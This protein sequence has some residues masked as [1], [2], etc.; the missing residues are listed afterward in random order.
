[1]GVGIPENCWN[2]MLKS[3]HFHARQQAVDRHFSSVNRLQ[4]Y[5]RYYSSEGCPNFYWFCTNLMN[6]PGDKQG[7][8]SSTEFP[9]TS[10]LLMLAASSESV[11][12]LLITGTHSTVL[13]ISRSSV[14]LCYKPH[15]DVRKQSTVPMRSGGSS[16]LQMGC[17]L[18]S[19]LIYAWPL[20]EYVNVGAFC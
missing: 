8:K 2:S 19:C 7:F 6:G 4:L 11:V 14:Y 18:A 1:M 3:V 12:N 20:L 16:F 17:Q 15:D 13:T 5:C 9:A 10:L